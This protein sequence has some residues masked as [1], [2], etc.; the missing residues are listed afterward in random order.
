MLRVGKPHAV[1]VVG[2][3]HAQTLGVLI[4]H[5]SENGLIPRHMLGQGHTGIITG[6]YDHPF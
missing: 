4:H 5:L 1:F 2:I 3:L 6:L